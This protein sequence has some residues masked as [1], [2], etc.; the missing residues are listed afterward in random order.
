MSYEETNFSTHFDPRTVNVIK[1]T[2]LVDCDILIAECAF[3]IEAIDKQ[4]ATPGFGGP[5]WRATALEAKNE[6][7]HK[8]HLAEMKRAAIAAALAERES[9]KPSPEQTFKSRFMK[10]AEE[11]LPP[12]TYQAIFEA[13]RFA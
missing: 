9:S 11:R 12:E 8:K 4:I 5:G 2:A 7:A 1:I 13:A 3:G 10:R 6:L